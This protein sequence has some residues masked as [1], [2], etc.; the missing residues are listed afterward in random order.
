M[1]LHIRVYANILLRFYNCYKY[2][3][4]IQ[5]L[6]SFFY[7]LLRGVDHFLKFISSHL[8]ESLELFVYIAI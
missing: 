8:S 2:L 3:T 6:D 4:N 5:I 7:R 1:L